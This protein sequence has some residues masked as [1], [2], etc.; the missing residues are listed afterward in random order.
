MDKAQEKMIELAQSVRHLEFSNV[1]EA[2]RSSFSGSMHLDL[3]FIQEAVVE[4]LK[5]RRVLK[6]TYAYG[7]YL[8]G[9]ISKKQFEHM[10][11]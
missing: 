4:L 7:Y 10:Q 5:G 9:L 11:V 6:A 1:S 2:Q 8:T 3:S